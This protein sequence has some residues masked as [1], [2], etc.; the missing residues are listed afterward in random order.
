MAKLE[1]QLAKLM[2]EVAKAEAEAEEI[3]Q[4]ANAPIPEAGDG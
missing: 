2:D 1:G 4:S 3:A